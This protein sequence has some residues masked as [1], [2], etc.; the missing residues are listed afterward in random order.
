M[1]QFEEARPYLLGY[2][3]DFKDVSRQLKDLKKI[4]PARKS[5]CYPLGDASGSSAYVNVPILSFLPE[6]GLLVALVESYMITF[7]V[8]HPLLSPLDFKQQ[9]EHLR[10]DSTPSISWLA[11]LY[12]M[13]ALGGNAISQQVLD[14]HGKTRDGLIGSCLDGAEAAFLRTPFASKPDLNA[15]QALCMIA[16]A[17]Q[18][19]LITNN[20]SDGLWS[21]M[22]FVIG[23]AIPMGL[24]R[25]PQWF[26]TMPVAEAEIRRR[27]W[28][29]IL[30][31][32]VYSALEA[33]LSLRIKPDD[34][35]TRPPSNMDNVDLF[36]IS[37]GRMP[38][39]ES[40]CDYTDSTYQIL[41]A[42][43]YPTLASILGAANAVN[44]HF[45]YYKMLELDLRIRQLL[46]ES[47]THLGCDVGNVTNRAT[48]LSSQSLQRHTYQIL[49]Q[50]GLL[51][52]HQ[53]FTFEWSDNNNGSHTASQCATN[54]SVLVVLELQQT[55]Y[56][57]YSPAATPSISAVT[58][59][60]PS[61]S[62]HSNLSNLPFAGSW[63]A[64]LHRDSFSIGFLHAILLLRQS[65]LAPSESNAT[66]LP[67]PTPPTKARM[68]TIEALRA[69]HN[70]LLSTSADSVSHLKTYIVFTFLLTALDAIKS[71]SDMNSSMHIAAKRII[72]NVKECRASGGENDEIAA[73]I[74]LRPNVATQFSEWTAST[75]DYGMNIQD[76]WLNGL[77]YEDFGAFE[78][79]G[80]ATTAFGDNS[81]SW[82]TG[83]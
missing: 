41:L 67:N 76:D 54:E 60:M 36:H 34:F 43:S 19:D 68:T 75:T 12:M 8:I 83:S 35:D 66:A 45:E 16:I 31:L 46:R 37:A 39:E 5:R 11:Q 74:G 10:S 52:L 14:Q 48:R 3:P 50:R 2:A 61:T 28:Y 81:Q 24:H 56:G 18:I 44:P 13:L 55:L 78:T 29:T 57:T 9:L 7:E 71:A 30:Y 27:M 26:P 72:R 64:S 4:F 59:T 77:G 70:I 20:D 1:T 47:E 58:T 79:N 65:Y 38:F 33:G 6:K 49:L 17:K 22:G 73:G 25:D 32:D 69:A 53:P 80:I 15:L 42:S 51:I 62:S 23:L 40:K 21:F 63:F 82:D